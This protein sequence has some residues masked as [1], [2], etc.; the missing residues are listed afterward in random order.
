[1]RKYFLRGLLKL[2][3]S[4][5]GQR[6]SIQSLMMN[7]LSPA[8]FLDTVNSYQRTAAIK[9]AI[10]LDLF[11]AIG[12]GRETSQALALRCG[13][14]ERGMR[15]LSDYLA[16]IGFLRKKRGRYGL[17]IDSAMLLDRRSPGYLADAIEFFLSPMLTD[18]FRDVTAVVRKGG[19]LLPEAGTI[20]PDRHVWV[21]FARA[22]APMSAVPAKKMARL[23]DKRPAQKLKVL[24]L[25]ASHG[26]YGI[27]IARRNKRAEVVAIDWECVLAV[28]KENALK[29]GIDNRYSTIAGSAFEVD[30]GKDY[31]LILLTNFLHHFDMTTCERLLGKVHAALAP[32]GRAV[33]VD[34][35][36]DAGRVS[37]PGPAAFCMTMLGTT[38]NGDA[39]TYDEFKRMLSN[40]GFMRSELRPLVS[41]FQQ[42][43][44]SYK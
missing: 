14:S 16:V 11:T 25:A 21:N 28:A 42:M 44:I 29:A 2:A 34:F 30:Y 15:I 8:L 36:P 12:E 38:P 7:R 19:T 6:S 13:A 27:E 43:I 41:N 24:D 5:I 37:P 22:M 17:T 4:R 35:V 26:M 39:Y 10:E 23:V 20:A 32:H 18:G 31:D 9:A 3:S 33:T 40:A 1:M